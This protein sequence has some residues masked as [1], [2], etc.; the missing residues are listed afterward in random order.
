MTPDRRTA[1]RKKRRSFQ[2]VME[3]DSGVV[4]S[5]ALPAHWVIHEYTPD[6]GGL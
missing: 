2:Q 5:A 4:L 3:E 6:Y 1:A